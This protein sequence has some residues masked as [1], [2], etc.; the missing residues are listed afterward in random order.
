MHASV[1]M[2]DQ[3]LCDQ[4]LELLRGG[5]AHLDFDAAVADLPSDLRGAHPPNLPHTPWRLVEHMRIAQRDILEF[6]RDPKHKS[7][8]WPDGYWPTGDAPPSSSAWDDCLA[9]FRAD[10]TAFVKLI[11]D[12]A[13]D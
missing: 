4:L 3:Q 6:C 5:N 1:H 7:P 9:R 8:K 10:H 12:P 11:A 2:N 13:S